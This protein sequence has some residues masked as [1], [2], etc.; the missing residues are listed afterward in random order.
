MTV[1]TDVEATDVLIIGRTADH[2]LPVD[3]NAP[4]SASAQNA[5]PK[6]GFLPFLPN[7]VEAPRQTCTGI[8]KDAVRCNATSP[9]AEE[10]GTPHPLLRPMT[11]DAKR[12]TLRA[13]QSPWTRVLLKHPPR[14]RQKLRLMTKKRWVA[15]DF[16]QKN[17]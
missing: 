15:I 7:L 4:A 6:I 8:E 1:K 13:T 10:D 2:H 14:C 11:R 16:Y 5:A 12:L 3:D 17:P 9:H